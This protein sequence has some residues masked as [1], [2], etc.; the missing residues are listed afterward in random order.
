MQEV[1]GSIPLS[2]TPRE[3]AGQ[4]A[5]GLLDLR[6]CNQRAACRLS[7]SGS[8]RAATARARV[9]RS[10]IAAVT[11]ASMAGSSRGTARPCARA[12]L[13]PAAARTEK[14][15]DRLTSAWR[16]RSETKRAECKQTRPGRKLLYGS[17]RAAGPDGPLAWPTPNVHIRGHSPPTQH[18]IP[19]LSFALNPSALAS[20]PAP[21]VRTR[22]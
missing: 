15:C 21:A 16:R 1:R 8:K 19:L 14:V 17:S 12:S 2:S 18:T 3:A 13:G 20:E 11:R 6:R 9:G 10:P 7:I 5:C 22:C 4:T